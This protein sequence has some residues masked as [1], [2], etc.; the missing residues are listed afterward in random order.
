MDLKKVLQDIRGAV[1]EDNVSKIEG[2]LNEIDGGFNV[3]NQ[4]LASVKNEAAQRRVRT[5]ELTSKVA[6]LEDQLKAGDKSGEIETLKSENEQLKSFQKQIHDQN[7]SSYLTQYEQLKSHKNFDKIKS[8][9][10]APAEVDGKLTLNE[11]VTNDQIQDSLDEISRAQEYGVFEQ[12]QQ[13]NPLTV[14]T[15]GDTQEIDFE[16][17]SRTDP[18]KARELKDQSYRERGLI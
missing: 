1:G 17:L 16:K 3:I 9:I 6:E 5:N 4:D 15:V 12:K 18:A 2:Y 14:P 10:I 13:T 7:R 11:S 8:K